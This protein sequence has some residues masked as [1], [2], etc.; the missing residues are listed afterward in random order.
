MLYSELIQPEG[1]SLA[2]SQ[3]GRSVER[4]AVQRTLVFPAE[5]ITAPAAA[6]SNFSIITFRMAIQAELRRALRRKP[7]VFRLVASGF[8]GPLLGL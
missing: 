2:A 3:P 4:E 7:V 6:V 5:M 1:G 8:F